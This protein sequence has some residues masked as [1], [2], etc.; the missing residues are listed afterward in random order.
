MVKTSII[1]PIWNKSE[2]THHFLYHNWRVYQTIPEVEFIVIDNG[3]QDNTPSI[4]VHWKK[5]MG[6]RLVIHTNPENRGFGP[7]NNQG[8][9]LARG[10]ILIFLSNDVIAMSDYVSIIKQELECIPTDLLGAQLL[11][12]DTGWNKFGDEI[13]PY[14]AG[15]CV[16]C[17]KSTWKQLG[18][19][20]E[21][22]VPCDYEDLD[23]SLTAKQ[24]GIPIRQVHLPLEHAFGQSAAQLEGGREAI[25]LKNRELFKEKWDFD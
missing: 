20:D 2:V 19:F 18:G 9:E 21:R 22:Y 8:A 24:E 5:T 3:S 17:T 4:L 14:L 11:A 6:D 25:T 1:T 10:D 13:V 23:L 16:A 15:W 7:A 12:Y